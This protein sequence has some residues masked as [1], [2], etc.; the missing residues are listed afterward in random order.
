MNRLAGLALIAVTML[1]AACEDPNTRG[2]RVHTGVSV[3]PGGV[4]PSVGVS[5]GRGP[6]HVGVGT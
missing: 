5:A 3:G 6:V 1:L 2:P 4:H